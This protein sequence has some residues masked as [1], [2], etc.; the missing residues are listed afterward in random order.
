[1]N[2][3]KVH[4]KA[5]LVACL[6]GVI[7]TLVGIPLF[8]AAGHAN[9]PNLVS[10]FVPFYAYTAYFSTADDYFWAK[11]AVLQWLYW[12]VLVMIYMYLKKLRK[13]RSSG[14]AKGDHHE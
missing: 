1:M 9:G 10:I 6:C 12:Y 8:V 13:S 5:L 7:A 11:F 4:L 2:K 14:H 3:I